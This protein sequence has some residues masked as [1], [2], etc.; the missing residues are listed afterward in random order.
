MPC[1][2]V[3]I[4]TPVR[5][6]GWVESVGVQVSPGLKLIICMC[7]CEGFVCAHVCAF[8]CSVSVTCE[9]VEARG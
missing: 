5:E 9:H 1:A 2:R 8:L 7:V 6:R 4:L 3:V